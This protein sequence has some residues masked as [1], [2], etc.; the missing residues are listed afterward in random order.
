MIW[1]R[2]VTTATNMGSAKNY[3]RNYLIINPLC[4]FCGQPATTIEHCPPRAMF[5]F[6]QWPEGFEFPSCETC[7]LGTGDHD[8]LIS[9]LARMDPF[10]QN[11]DADGRQVGLMKMAALDLAC[12][13]ASSRGCESNLSERARSQSFNRRPSISLDGYILAMKKTHANE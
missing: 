2:K 8:L 12:S 4:A 9:M 3:R 5:Q 6:R 7:N 10:E 1:R 13:R 11:G